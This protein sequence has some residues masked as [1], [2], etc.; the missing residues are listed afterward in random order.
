MAIRRERVDLGTVHIQI[1][2]Y[3]F[4]DG[5]VRRTLAT[6]GTLFDGLL[7]RSTV[8]G[9]TERIEVHRD[10]ALDVIAHDGSSQ[11]EK[12]TAVWEGWEAAAAALRASGA[13]GPSVTGHVA[14]LAAS[15]G[16]VPKASLDQAEITWS[17]VAGDRQ[18]N[19]KH[20]GAPWQA[21]C[22]WSSEVIDAFAAEGHDLAPARG[23]ENV[24][25]TGFPWDSVGP[26]SLIRL[27][28]SVCQVWGYT[29]PCKNFTQWF[30]GGRIKP[31]HRRNEVTRVYASVVQPGRV[32]VADPAVLGVN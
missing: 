12:L 31:E 13:L 4:S 8:P 2:P 16:G 15:G 22:L 24:T 32:S 10:T 9:F 20:H 5:D 30:A 6:A 14:H 7:A 26:G 23:G 1:G 21:L 29:T 3:S 19:R 18:S 11:A 25:I 28:D 27:G 17:G